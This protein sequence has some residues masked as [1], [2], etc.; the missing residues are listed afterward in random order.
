MSRQKQSRF[1]DNKTSPNLLEAGKSLFENIKGSWNQELF[2]NN[3]S[4]TL[5]VGCGKGE[6]T[7]GLSRKFADRNFIG[8][9]IKGDRLWVGS[10]QAIKENLYNAAF[11]RTQVQ[12]L[13]QFFE[14]GELDEIWV[15]FPDPRPKERDEKRRLTH[16]NYLAIYKKLL[17]KGGWVKFKTDNTGLF[18]Y[19]LD[20]LQTGVIPVTELTYTHDLYKS[21]LFLEHFD[22]MTKY[23]R[24]FSSQGENIKYL[25]FKFQN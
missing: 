25:K 13:D 5:E 21:N 1:S 8:V 2:R 3:Q 7:I 12:F 10:R 15:T 4:I 17:S 20:L 6:Y 23:E 18:N 24:K 9:D 11:L 22:I 16:P 14:V 19:T